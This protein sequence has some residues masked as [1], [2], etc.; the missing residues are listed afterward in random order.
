VNVY[1]QGSTGHSIVAFDTVDRGMIF[2][3]PQHDQEVS[4]V[5]GSSYCELNDLQGANDDVIID[6]VLIP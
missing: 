1:F 3:E 5:K 4:L 2:I 6:Y